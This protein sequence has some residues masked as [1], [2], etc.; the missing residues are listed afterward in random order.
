MRRLMSVALMGFALA[1]TSTVAAAQAGRAGL[2]GAPLDSARALRIDS[3]RAARGDTA[4][5]RMAADSTRGRRGPGAENA[6]AALA[7][8]NL[9]AAQKNDIKSIN[10]KY[11]DQMKQLRAANG[12][13]GVAASATDR[14]QMKAIAERERAEVRGVLTTAQ[15]TQFDANIAK[16][17]AGK[18]GKGHGPRQ[19][20]K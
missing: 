20:G 8:L 7:G 11:A 12:K 4:S 19:F 15:Q 2:R 1:G 14:T 16:H 3:L 9:T 5:R 13:T 10:K 6:R 18:K 17:R